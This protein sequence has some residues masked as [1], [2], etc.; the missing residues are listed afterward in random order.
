MKGAPPVPPLTTPATL[1]APL[2]IWTAAPP[3]PPRKQFTIA[4][5]AMVPPPLPPPL[6]A[7]KAAPPV[8]LRK[9]L[10]IATPA[11]ADQM[12]SLGSTN[13]CTGI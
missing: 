2:T 3:V 7:M 6:T 1:P 8:T 4:T 11:M 5:H 10:I 9:Q 12:P 13:S